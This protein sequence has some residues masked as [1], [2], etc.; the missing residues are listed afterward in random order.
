MVKAERLPSGSYRIKVLDYKD[1]DGK[2]H[3]RSFTGKNK[4]AVQLEAAQFE[5][6]RKDNRAGNIAVCCAMERY[7][8]SK[9]NVISPRTYRE[10]TQMRKNSLKM[11]HQINVNDLTREDVQ[12]AVNAEAESHAPKTVRNMHGLLSSALKMFRPD[13]TLLTTLPQK[14]KSDIIIPTE[15]DVMRL[16]K[17]VYDTDIELPVLL[18]ALAGMRSSEIVGLKWANVDLGAGTIKVDTALVRDIH[19]N[20]VE[21]APKSHAGYRIIKMIP[22]LR[23]EMS[24]LYTSDAV[25]VTPLK[26]NQIYTRYQ[27]ALARVCPGAHYTFHELRHYAASVMI[28][29]GIPVKY[30]ADM[31]GHETEEMVNRVYGHIM[32]DKK[33]QFFERLETYYSDTFKRYL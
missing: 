21:K 26:A 6:Q 20:F 15:E 11:L 31:L 14:E 23:D 4:K 30:I 9:K 28:M 27:R 8:E 29:L 19:N 12:A 3:Y 1:E 17:D 22:Y 2:A 16:I 33:D 10:Y 24:R 32:R 13:F 18:A 7:V 5:A 25:F